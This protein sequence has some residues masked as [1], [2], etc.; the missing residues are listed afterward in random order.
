MVAG[1][2]DGRQHHHR[3]QQP[4]DAQQRVPSDQHQGD[5]EDQRPGKV[6]TGHGRVGIVPYLGLLQFV[7]E[8][9]RQ[10]VDEPV[11]MRQVQCG[12]HQPWR[13]HRKRDVD[14]QRQ[15]GGDEDDVAHQPEEALAKQI[16]PGQEEQRAEKVAVEVEVVDERDDLVA[17]DGQRADQP[18]LMAK[19]DGLQVP[20]VEDIPALFD[21]DY[22]QAVVQSQHVLLGYQTPAKLVDFLQDEDDQQVD[23]QMP[24]APYHPIKRLCDC[25]LH[26]VEIV[27][28]WRAYVRVHILYYRASPD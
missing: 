12:A 17:I 3:I 9:R 13:H 2:H 11:A 4:E 14:D 5:A 18:L 6:Q 7:V 19:D 24:E 27:L 20:F 10:R 25:H 1:D 23:A 8:N 21:L 15:A 26:V 16:D 22:E 28:L